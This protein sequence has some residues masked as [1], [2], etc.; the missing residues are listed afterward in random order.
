MDTQDCW[1]PAKQYTRL[2]DRRDYAFLSEL[3]RAD[4]RLVVGAND[5]GAPPVFEF[6]GADAIVNAM[7][8]L[9]MYDSTFHQLGQQQILE[10]SADPLLT[11][12]YCTA[13]H[14]YT[15]DDRNCCYTLFI[16]YL[17]TLVND[18]GSGDFR[19]VCCIFRAN[20]ACPHSTPDP[21]LPCTNSR[22]PPPN[23]AP[24]NPDRPQLPF[25][26]DDAPLG[27]RRSYLD[28]MCHR[29]SYNASVSRPNRTFSA[30]RPHPYGTT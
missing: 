29:P 6:E 2:I 27:N 17:D 28:P 11:E 15:Q 8:A 22:L 24:T 7:S 20:K 16:R 21:D 1:L 9:D 30:Q 18:G 10:C 12:S 14:F 13:S 5:Q 3:F 26:Q 23:S 25:D 19:R 4:A